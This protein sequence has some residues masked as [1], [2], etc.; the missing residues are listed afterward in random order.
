MFDHVEGEALI[1]L[2]LLEQLNHVGDALRSQPMRGRVVAFARLGNGDIQWHNQVVKLRSNPECLGA[3]NGIRPAV[4]VLHIPVEDHIDICGENL[5]GGVPDEL[6]AGFRQLCVPVIIEWQAMQ[7]Q[8]P[9]V[10]TESDSGKGLGELLGQGCLSCTVQSR[11]Q[12]DVSCH[13]RIVSGCLI[14]SR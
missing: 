8:H 14:T 2:R 11:Q 12:V 7:P 1:W 3:T 9:L 5:C 10:Q 4:A 6:A 13:S